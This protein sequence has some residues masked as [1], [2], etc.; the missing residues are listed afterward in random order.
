MAFR[1]ETNTTRYHDRIQLSEENGGTRLVYDAE[2]TLTGMLE[3]GEPFFQVLFEKI[4]R[5]AT[6]PIPDAV[7]RAFPVNSSQVPPAT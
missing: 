1:G 3:L 5:D 7:V 4:G 6:D 2:L